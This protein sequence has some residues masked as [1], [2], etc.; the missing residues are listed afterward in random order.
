MYFRK[1]KLT[2]KSN[3]INDSDKK[4]ITFVKCNGMKK[5]YRFVM[6]DQESRNFAVA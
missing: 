1:K 2:A 5:R 4:W 3:G 6:I